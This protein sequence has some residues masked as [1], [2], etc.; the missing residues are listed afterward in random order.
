LATFKVFY[1]NLRSI[2]NSWWFLVLLIMPIRRIE[3][4]AFQR[5]SGLYLSLFGRF[6]KDNGRR[7]S[8]IIMVGFE[9][10]D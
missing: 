10:V 2:L 5:V 4:H 3:V 6:G 1:D 8:G 7:R 9:P